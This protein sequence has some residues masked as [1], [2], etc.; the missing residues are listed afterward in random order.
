MS[1]FGG[2][3]DIGHRVP[4]R[5]VLRGYITQSWDIWRVANIPSALH[6]AC[7]FISWGR[8]MCKVFRGC[9]G[10]RQS[11]GLQP[12]QTGRTGLQAAC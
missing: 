2:K 1:A 9:T 3:A 12:D 11:A 10:G 4:P 5:L 6:W 8:N 7:V